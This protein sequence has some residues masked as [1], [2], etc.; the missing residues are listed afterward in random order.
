MARTKKI[1]VSKIQ[2]IANNI[3]PIINKIE[4]NDIEIEIKNTL[5]VEECIRLVKNATDNCFTDDGEFLP[6]MLAFSI[7]VSTIAV[8]TNLEL[9]DSTEDKYK[10]ITYTDLMEK[11]TSNINQ[12]QYEDLL[13]AIDDKVE[14]KTKTNIEAIR[15]QV[16]E[17]YFK[18]EEL[19]NQIAETFS[20]S[21]M[22]DFKTMISAVANHE[23]DEGKI[24][25]AYLSH[26]K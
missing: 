10:V 18:A 9:P 8:Y 23:V 11:I 21:G 3:T 15:V 25:E 1:K 5:S 19:F 20:Q 7:G 17:L 26:S 22:E 24:M 16:N 12:L 14:Y 4:W 6:E 2:E 13:H